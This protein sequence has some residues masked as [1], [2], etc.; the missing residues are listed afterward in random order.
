MAGALRF[1]ARL[2]AGLMVA[3]WA[4]VAAAATIQATYSLSGAA[5]SGPGLTVATDRMSGSFSQ[6]LNVGQSVSFKLF[7]IWTSEPTIDN[8]DL[9]GESLVTAF[10]FSQPGVTGSLAGTVVGRS[11]FFNIVQSG[12]LSYSAPLILTWGNGGQIRISLSSVSYNAGLFGLSGG[13]GNGADVM[14]TLTYTSAP[15]PT[16]PLPAAGAGLAG[17]LAVTALV[18]RRRRAA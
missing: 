3:C 8:D 16:V 1:V 2:A 6:N 13:S 9:V 17:A 4:G 7:R 10:S 12:S 11:T 15:I 18:R 14:A 5:F